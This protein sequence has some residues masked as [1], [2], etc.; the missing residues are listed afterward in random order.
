MENLLWNTMRKFIRSK[1]LHNLQ[2]GN[3]TRVFPTELL[4]ID[5]NDKKYPKSLKSLDIGTKAKS[6]FAAS[7]VLDMCEEGKKFRQ[8]CLS[9]YI[10]TVAHMTTILPFN[11]F[12]KNCSYIHPLKRNETNALEEFL[13]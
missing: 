6:M 10:N 9:T 3:K 12:L 4:L 7:D 1:Y 11:T 13:I 2:N 5:V 8:N